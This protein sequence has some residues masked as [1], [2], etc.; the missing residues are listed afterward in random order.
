MQSLFFGDSA[1]KM[2]P[3][4]A[5]GVDPQQTWLLKQ[6]YAVLHGIEKDAST[7]VFVGMQGASGGGPNDAR[8]GYSG[9]ARALCIASG[10][11]S[12]TLGLTGPCITLDTACSASLVAVH[13]ASADLQRAVCSR[14]LAFGVEF[15][16]SHVTQSFS[17]A[18]MLSAV[19]RCH[20]FDATADGYCRGEGCVVL[21]LESMSQSMYCAVV[22]SAV[23]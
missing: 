14:A 7:G 12:Y 20:T 6:S 8:P 18:G 3:V 9:T 23:Q 19:G 5:R 16:S 21:M 11:I 1:L 17:A 2:S 15:L 13:L 22:G 4:E 10:R